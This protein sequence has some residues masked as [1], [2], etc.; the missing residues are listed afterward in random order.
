MI[1]DAE[2]MFELTKAIAE[3][4]VKRFDFWPIVSEATREAMLRI[5]RELP[6]VDISVTY[7]AAFPRDLED[8]ERYGARAVCIMGGVPANPALGTSRYPTSAAQLIDIACEA[9]RRSK[10]QGLRV[11][12]ATGGTFKSPREELGKLFSAVAK[13]GVDAISAADSF[14]QMTPWGVEGMVRQ[15]REWVG[16]NVKVEIHCHNDMGMA[17]ANSLAAVKAGADVVHAAVNGYGE[18][19]GNASLEEVALGAEMLLGVNTGIELSK[20]T[21]LSER[22]SEITRIP[23]PHAKPVVGEWQS[24]EWTGMQVEWR[25]NGIASGLPE[26]SYSFLPQVVGAHK[27]HLALGPMVGAAVIVAKAEELGIELPDGGISM[28]RDRIKD[29][30]TERREL[31][32]D[33]EFKQIVAD[34]AEYIRVHGKPTKVS[35]SA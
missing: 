14:G 3:V 13:E 30:S 20:L 23:L 33:D 28:I 4:G 31:I 22:A 17:T 6:H 10:E 1:L 16:P 24:I 9:V 26:Q 19:A 32:G 2:A 34:T 25:K 15:M 18:R 11:C 7:R 21:W 12:Y 35:A 8:A 27:P 29:D 5:S